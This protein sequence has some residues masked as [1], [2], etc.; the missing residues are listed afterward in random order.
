MAYKTQEDNEELDARFSKLI[1]R[2]LS[3]PDY[4]ILVAKAWKADREKCYLAETRLHELLETSMNTSSDKLKIATADLK[5]V[6][7]VDASNAATHKKDDN[8]SGI[9]ML[10]A[11][12]RLGVS[13]RTIQRRIESGDIKT[14]KLGSDKTSPVRILE[15]DLLAY[16]EKCKTAT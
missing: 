1:E 14:I 16:V 10:Q 12:K 2:T 8:G 3:D 11:A 6:R 13:K 15:D 4:L 9:T 7:Q 5:T